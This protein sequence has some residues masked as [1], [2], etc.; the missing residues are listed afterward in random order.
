MLQ[1]VKTATYVIFIIAFKKNLNIKDLAS[2][3]YLIKAPNYYPGIFSTPLIIPI[4]PSFYSTSSP[5]L[6]Q[7]ITRKKNTKSFFF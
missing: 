1:D 5:K 7:K 6:V 4:S 2:L 3:L